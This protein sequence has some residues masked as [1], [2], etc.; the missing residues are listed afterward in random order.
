MKRRG[1]SLLETVIGMVIFS[2][3]GILTF[4]IF[5]WS[6]STFQLT[7]VRLELQ[8]E[9]RRINAAVRR[10]ML[11]SAFVSVSSRFSNVSVTL[12]P[13]STNPA[14]TQVC[15]R[16]AISFS[17]MIDPT[18]P[19]SYTTQFGFSL[20]NCTTIYY[21]YTL[22]GEPYDCRL[23]RYKVSWDDPVTSVSGTTLQSPLAG[24]GLPDSR[25]DWPNPSRLITQFGVHCYSNR[26]RCFTI[27]PNPG[28]QTLELNVT[29]QGPLG[30]SSVGTKSTAEIVESSVLLK[31][32]NT[33]PKL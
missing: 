4:Q 26:I 6:S 12:P 23:Y 28:D 25:Y 27:K 9:I 1:F 15:A 22:P 33:W 11:E 8:G 18:S 24:F 21:P 16:D 32:E 29:L 5:A 17:S 7:T 20:F 30:H 31:C 2:L 13:G 10:D 19:N 14:D 3:L